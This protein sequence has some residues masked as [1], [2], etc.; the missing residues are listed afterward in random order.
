MTK[1]FKI[2]NLRVIMIELIILIHKYNKINEDR[3]KLILG[4]Y[5]FYLSILTQ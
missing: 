3:S 4:I 2:R 5:F 1:I